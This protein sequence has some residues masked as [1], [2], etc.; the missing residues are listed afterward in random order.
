MQK[1]AR[2]YGITL[3][4]VSA[5]LAASAVIYSIQEHIPARIALPLA[6]ALLVEV[7]LYLVPGFSSGRAFVETFQP[8][9]LRALLIQLSTLVPYLIYSVGTGTFH[10][11]NFA[12][13]AGLTTI[14][15]A[16][17]AVRR[18]QHLVTDLLFMAVA[19]IVVLLK[20]FP[21]IYI[22]LAPHAT[23][24]ILGQLMWFRL[25]FLAVLCIRGMSGINF[26]LVPSRK[27]WS[28]GIQHYLMFIPAALVAGMLLH[29]AQPHAAFTVWWKGAAL[30]A[31]TFAAF[32]WVV[33][34]W[35]EFYFRGMLQQLLTKRLG[36][37]MT[38]LV[39][40]S[41]I[42]GLAHLPFRQFPNWKMALLAGLA[43]GFYGWAYIRAG[44]IRAAMVTHALVVTTWKV[45]FA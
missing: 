13:L 33:A 45:F 30:A 11:R 3:I 4:V 15:A 12:L 8:L 39:T 23:A 29:F 27:D 22:E 36:G 20:V 43:G 35:E 26:G 41:V 16:W 24:S 5:L 6:A 9:P 38:G 2:A 25:Q 31:G 17:Y 14:L 10:W 37:T 1:D 40:T 18:P 21:R 7:G 42:F 44:S 19:G 34:L 32:L 28:I